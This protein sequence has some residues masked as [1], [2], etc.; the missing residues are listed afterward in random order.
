[1]VVAAGATGSTPKGARHRRLPQLQ[2]WLLPEVPTALPRGPT[3][4]VWVNLVH[5]TSIFLATHTRGPLW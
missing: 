4:D 2:W 3:I 1:M 5:V